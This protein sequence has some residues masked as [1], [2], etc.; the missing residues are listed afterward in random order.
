MTRTCRR[1]GGM[2]PAFLARVELPSIQRRTVREQLADLQIVPDPF[3]ALSRIHEI[4]CDGDATN[5]LSAT[6]DAACERGV[7]WRSALEELDPDRECA[8]GRL[9]HDHNITCGCWPHPESTEEVEVEALTAPHHGAEATAPDAPFGYKDDGTPRRRAAPSEEH[10]EAIRRGHRE[11]K[12]AREA[13]RAAH[14]TATPEPEPEP[15]ADVVTDVDAL[16]AQLAALTPEIDPAIETLEKEIERLTG[17]VNRLRA[18]RV[19]SLSVP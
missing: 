17:R 2:D 3:V 5:V 11:R 9:P 1:L 4:E 16:L 7:L 13:Q 6:E 19:A 10:V 12:A 15:V 18:I 14:A 8:H